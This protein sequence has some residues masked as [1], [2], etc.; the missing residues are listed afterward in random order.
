MYGS[1]T[2]TAEELSG[3]LA[4]DFTRYTKKVSTVHYCYRFHRFLSLFSFIVVFSRAMGNYPIFDF[5]GFDN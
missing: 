2:G 1:Q 5:P 3:R 4:K